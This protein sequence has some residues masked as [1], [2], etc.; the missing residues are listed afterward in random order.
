MARH[1][2]L[3]LSITLLALILACIFSVAKPITFQ[4]QIEKREKLVKQQ[5]LRIRQA[6]ESYRKK[7]GTY[8][9]NWDELIREKLLDKQTTIIPFSDN[10]PFSLQVSNDVAL[11]GATLPLV[12]CQAQYKDYLNGLDKKEIER[13]TLQTEKQGQFPGLKFGDMNKPNN[14][15]T[16]W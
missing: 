12:E 4:Q 10:K 6:E 8:T 15:A 11:S 14:N 16:N 3:L 5:L 9:D 7:H 1:A 13:I 2:K